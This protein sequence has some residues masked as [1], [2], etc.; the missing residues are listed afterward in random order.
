MFKTEKSILIICIILIFLLSGQVSATDTPTIEL[1]DFDTGENSFN[2]NANDMIED[3]DDE[4]KIV[5]DYDKYIDDEINEEDYVSTEI[6]A[7]HPIEN[8]I[9]YPIKNNIDYPIENNVDFPIENNVNY[10]INNNVDDEEFNIVDENAKDTTGVIMAGDNYSCGPA[11]LATVLNKFGLNLSLSEVSRYTKT[12]LNGT[13]MQSLM[14]AAKQYNFSALGI[15][16]DTKNLKE[17]YIVHLNINGNE[18]WTVISKLTDTHVFLADSTEGNIK[19]S[20]DEFNSYF[21]KKAVVISNN[22]QIDLNN[23]MIKNQIKI[24]GKNQTL[25]ISGKGMKRRVIGYKIVW[26]H[27]LIAKH[28]WILKP[29]VVGGHVSFSQ[30]QYVKGTY[31]VWGKYKVKEPIYKYYYVADDSLT[32]AKIKKRK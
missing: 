22:S 17:N 19:L 16:I 18:H 13:N 7:N 26:K 11:S 3:M 21:T 10:P 24:L 31:Y 1:N 9:D 20:L 27:G 29:K 6:N 12:S 28:G 23:E 30:W 5:E 15:E 25:R 2:T 8:N 4:I 14:D 32:S